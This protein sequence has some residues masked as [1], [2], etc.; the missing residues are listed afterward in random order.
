MQH[1]VIRT[2][3]CLQIMCNSEV[4]KEAA[5]ELSLDTLQQLSI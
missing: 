1:L 5:N 2:R 3:G 4:S